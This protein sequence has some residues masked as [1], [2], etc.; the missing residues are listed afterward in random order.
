MQSQT[1]YRMHVD[2]NEQ[3]EKQTQLSHAVIYL[4]CYYS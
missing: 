4:N 3:H 1:T 2:S